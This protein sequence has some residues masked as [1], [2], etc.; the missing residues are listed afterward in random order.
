MHIS[1]EKCEFAEAERELHRL[2]FPGCQRDPAETA[3]LFHRP[4]D[5]TDLVANVELHHFVTRHL[6]RVGHVHRNFCVAL[7]SD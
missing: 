1:I 6:A 5:R 3:Q 2:G 7:R 4:G